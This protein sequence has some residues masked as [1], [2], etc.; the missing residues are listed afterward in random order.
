[1]GRRIVSAVLALFCVLLLLGAAPGEQDTN[2]GFSLIVASD[3]HYL[4]P[5]LT[6]HGVYFQAVMAN[7]DGKVT[8]YC[9]EITDAFLSEVIRQKPQALIL[10]GDLSFNGARASHESLAAKLRAVE[11]AGIPVYVLP[12]N[13][14]LFRKTA[15]AFFGNGYE[16]VPSVTGEEFREIYAAFGFEEALSRDEHSLSYT[17]RLNDES[18]LLMLDANTAH[19]FCSLSEKTLAWA[20]EQLKLA[21][22]QGL[23]V[24]AACHQNLFPHSMFREGYMLECAGT[25]YE[26]LEQYQVPLFL[27]GHMHIQHIVTIENVTEIA[28]SSLTMGDCRYGILRREGDGIQF[29]AR[30][31][32]LNSWAEEQGREDLPDFPAYARE[33]LDSRT[34]GQ[35]E[36]MLKNKDYPEEQREALL[37]YACALN[38]AYFTGDLSGIPALDPDGSLQREW[39]SNATFFS[40]YFASIARDIGADY[41]VWSS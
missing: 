38:T 4:S 34:R 11:E 12:G 20:E 17:A 26:L 10:T 29:E 33:S 8:E 27:S 1:M 18:L 5:E 21:Q 16:L 6:D 13:H 15:A 25:L 30:P 7:G 3:L 22:E 40:T 23:Y 14:D 31:V 37:E 39:E 28:L 35:A 9:E 36:S 32:D 19:D 41:T 2:S 24:L